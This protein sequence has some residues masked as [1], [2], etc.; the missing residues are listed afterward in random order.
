M[1]TYNFNLNGKNQSCTPKEMR[2]LL[3]EQQI[4]LVHKVTK[5]GGQI[6]LKNEINNR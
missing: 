4:K 5:Q 2:K 1:K 6:I 3:T